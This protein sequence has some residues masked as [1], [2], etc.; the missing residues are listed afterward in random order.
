MYVSET[1]RWVFFLLTRCGHVADNG[2]FPDPVSNMVYRHFAV[3]RWRMGKRRWRTSARGSKVTQQCVGRRAMI[4]S[5][6]L[7]I[8]I[9]SEW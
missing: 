7:Y 9:D 2:G 3:N 5:I 4:L 8:V 1:I 6:G